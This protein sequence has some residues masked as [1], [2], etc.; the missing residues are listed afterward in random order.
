MKTIHVKKLLLS[1]SSLFIIIA[2]A[3]QDLRL[4]RNNRGL[5]GFVNAKGDTVVKPVY[6]S[7]PGLFKEERAIVR[8]ANNKFAIID[9]K[10]KELFPAKYDAIQGFSNGYSIVTMN[11]AD[12]NRP[13]VNTYSTPYGKKTFTLYGLIDR[14]GNEIIPPLYDGVNGDFSNGWFVRA[15]LPNYKY[16]YFTSNGDTLVLPAYSSLMLDKIDG[17]KFLATK[18]GRYGIIDNK[19][20]ELV[21]FEYN[22]IRVEDNGLLVLTQDGKS[23]IMDTKLKWILK[24]SYKSIQKFYKGYAIVQDTAGKFGAINE[25]A[26]VTTPIQYPSLMAIDKAWSPFAVV[27]NKGMGMSGM[28]NLATGKLVIP[29]QYSFNTYNYSDGFIQFRRDNKKGLLD[30]TGKELFFDMYDDFSPGFLDGMAW[31]MKDKQYG[32]MDTKGVLA[33]PAQYQSVRGFSNGLAIVKQN[34]KYGMIDKQGKPVLPA[35]YDDILGFSEDMSVIKKDNL[36]GFIDK[37]GK[38]VI[39]PAYTY[40]SSFDGGNAFVQKDGQYFYI[41]KKGNKQ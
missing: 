26:V 2:I 28:V 33:I 38:V 8:G 32:F 27:E 15:S 12:S 23:G 7:K 41:D 35:E 29:V 10:G 4:I 11:Y 25:K 24:P 13:Q 18:G 6:R 22:Y 17:K 40:A 37:T 21:P 19:W 5:F 36:Y 30:S 31:V 16:K 39:P 9:T 3:A 1:L 34:N 20:N 14:N